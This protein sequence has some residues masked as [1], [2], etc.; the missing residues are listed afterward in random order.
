MREV[1]KNKNAKTL[2]FIHMKYFLHVFNTVIEFDQVAPKNTLP[3]SW[4]TA[5][6]NGSLGTEQKTAHT[7]STL[8]AQKLRKYCSKLSE[9]T[10]FYCTS[11]L[12]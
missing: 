8:S 11:E 5:N 3:E 9:I 1:F 4:R 10:F 12:L 2:L 7:E 6:I